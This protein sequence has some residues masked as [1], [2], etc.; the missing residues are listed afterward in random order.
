VNNCSTDTTE[1]FIT[2]ELNQDCEKLNIK[3]KYIL[4]KENLGGAGGFE[5]AFKEAMKLN[6]DLFWIMD[7]DILPNK[8][9]LKICVDNLDCQHQIIVPKRIGEGFKDSIVIKYRFSNPLVYLFLKR[10]VQPKKANKD[11]YDVEAFTFEG[12]LISK[13]IIHK[14]GLPNSNY[15]LQGDD[16]DYAFRCLKFTKIK[17]VTSAIIKRQI[18][19]NNVKPGNGNYWRLYYS[20][21]NMTFLDLRYS[22]IKLFSRI[23]ILNNK[24]KWKLISFKH[25][26]KKEKLVV[27]KAFFDA[28]HNNDGKT[29]NPGD[30]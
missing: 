24:I 21:R 22:K 20:I 25:K 5:I 18:P 29:I 1:K 16:Y 26:D 3:L 27:K 6:Y 7:D 4:T 14:V 15:F 17:Y 9:C 19:I 2:E 13:E 8:D 28:L 11:S 23:R 30:L 12:P 10:I